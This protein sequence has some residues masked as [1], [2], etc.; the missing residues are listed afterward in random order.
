M[1]GAGN[2]AFVLRGKL[3]R[4]FDEGGVL[5][6]DPTLFA[7]EIFNLIP[8]TADIKIGEAVAGVDLGDLGGTGAGFG[9]DL[10]PAG[11]SRRNLDIRFGDGGGSG[12][13][14]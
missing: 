12:D 11:R 7:F 5:G 9:A 4:S 10:E 8:G 2:W 1:G 13:F 14:G 3:V 6:R